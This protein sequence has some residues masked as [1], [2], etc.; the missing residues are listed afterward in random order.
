MKLFPSPQIQFLKTIFSWFLLCIIFFIGSHTP[1]YAQMHMPVQQNEAGFF[2]S[3]L[4]SLGLEFVNFTLGAIALMVIIIVQRQQSKLATSS[5]LKY[6]LIGIIFLGVIRLFL[7]LN[8]LNIIGFEDEI[9]TMIWHI[10]FY[11]AMVFFLVG[12][13]ELMN[14]SHFISNIPSRFKLLILTIILVIGTVLIILATLTNSPY[15]YI[16]G[17]TFWEQYG[18]QHFIAFI[19]AGILAFYIAKLRK[20][21]APNIATI[22]MPLLFAFAFL[23]MIH[24]WELVTESY[25]IFPV[26]HDIIER[27]EQILTIP[28]YGFIIYAFIKRPNQL[29]QHRD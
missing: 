5:A 14:V 27:I 13:V 4:L 2:S 12:T 25:K 18:I 3:E 20:S 16:F 15:L 6:Y 28:G 1:I 26:H 17:I 10:L 9:A 7:L 11:F 22:V 19:F 21:S 8:S 29:E 24:L 23:S